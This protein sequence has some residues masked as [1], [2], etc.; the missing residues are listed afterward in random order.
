MPSVATSTMW[1][2]SSSESDIMTNHLLDTGDIF[3]QAKLFDQLP[4]FRGEGQV[5]RILL[6]HIVQ[7]LEDAFGVADGAKLQQCLQ[8]FLR[9]H[10]HHRLSCDDFFL[11]CGWRQRR[12]C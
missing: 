1:P 7:L 6:F 9:G 3:I 2:L 4:K 12:W 11:E 5:R 8:F 10:Q